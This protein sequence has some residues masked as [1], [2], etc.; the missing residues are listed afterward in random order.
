MKKVVQ[1]IFENILL[2]IAAIAF[3]M[4]GFCIAIVLLI[5]AVFERKPKGNSINP[6]NNTNL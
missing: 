2:L 4:V 1:S 3:A 5:D 6:K